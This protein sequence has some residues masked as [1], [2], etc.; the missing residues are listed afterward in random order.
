MFGIPDPETLAM[1]RPE[2]E[3]YGYSDLPT[4]FAVHRAEANRFKKSIESFSRIAT[5]ESRG[6]F[7]V[8]P[9]Y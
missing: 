4:L 1:M 5:Q 2:F 7:V 3:R 6:E 9:L 8:F